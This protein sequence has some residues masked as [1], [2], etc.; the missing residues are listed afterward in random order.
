[1]YL[2]AQVHGADR[3]SVALARMA[4]TALERTGTTVARVLHQVERQERTMLSLGWHPH[5]TP[6]GSVPPSPPWRISGDLSRSVKVEEP[7]LRGATWTGRSG[8]TSPYGR[9]HELGG[10]TG[11]GHRTYL[12]AR[13]H[14]KPA[15]TIVR[16]TVRATFV[17]DWTVATRPR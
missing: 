15:W 2:T 1:M 10:W 6:T 12:P 4:A 8:P 7:T 5:G 11:A 9:I 3:V 16:P 14:L 17:R 13:P